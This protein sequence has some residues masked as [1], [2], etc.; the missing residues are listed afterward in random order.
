MI[1]KLGIVGGG[2]LGRMLALAAAPLGVECRFVDPSPEAGA[3]VAATQIEAQFDNID[4]LH[5]LAEWSDV[6][7]FEF[8]NVPAPALE[9]IAAHATLAPPPRSLEVSQDR[10]A[11]KQLFESLG[12]PVAPYRAVDSFED[13]KQAIAEVGTPS[14][15][16]TRRL[17][18]DGK[19][20]T[21]LTSPEDAEH[22]WHALKGAPS[23]LEG[24]VDFTREVSMIVVRS[25]DGGG[26]WYPLTENVHEGGILRRSTAP[27]A[28]F[29]DPVQTSAVNLAVS[30]ADALEHVGVLTIELFDTV[31]GLVI[32]EIAPRVH[33]SGHWT[34][35]GC[36]SSQFENHVRAVIGLPTGSIGP[37]TPSVMINLIGGIPE[38]A[39]VLAVPGAHLHLYDKEPRAGRKVGHVTVVDLPGEDSLAERAK[40]VEEL[41][42]AATV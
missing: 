15:L 17:G 35:E 29:D 19:G 42:R 12:L 1:A 5:D 23:V 7:T 20:Q 10:L 21:R 16:K 24:L 3:R 8:E 28:E 36:G 31:D 22:A 2:Q 26:T 40:R 4:A 25:R 32:N 11:E 38:A 37:V 39:D 34:I 30:V 27:V 41:A 13:L 9:A 14:I 33:N 6:V 18:Y